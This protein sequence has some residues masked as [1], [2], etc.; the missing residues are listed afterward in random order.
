MI[1][2]ISICIMIFYM[3]NLLAQIVKN[4]FSLHK[5]QIVKKNI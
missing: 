1:S 5:L 3:I 4:D 2:Y